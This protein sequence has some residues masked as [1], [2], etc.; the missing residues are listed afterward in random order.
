MRLSLA[1]GMDDKMAPADLPPEHRHAGQRARWTI[2]II[3]L[4]LIAVI[5]GSIWENHH[6]KTQKANSNAPIS[7]RDRQPG[8]VD[9]KIN[10]AA[11]L[12]G[13]KLTVTK[14]AILNISTEPNANANPIH[15][16]QY[17][18]ADITLEGS[19]KNP[20]NYSFS[21]FSVLT[22]I[23]T[24]AALAPTNL[25]LGI[26]NPLGSGSLTSGKKIN[27]QV[28]MPLSGG[29]KYHYVVFTPKEGQPKRLVVGP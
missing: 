13:V 23:K 19:N 1:T 8:D 25:P 3:V 21:Q 24:L 29:F 26:N 9:A 28:V 6:H 14:T 15:I 10:Q 5:G 16:G 22:D 20:A 18:I 4:V 27:G 7:R 12:D 2:A 17:L 11:E